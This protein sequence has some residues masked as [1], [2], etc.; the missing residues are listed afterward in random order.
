[1]KP[2]KNTSSHNRRWLIPI[3][4]T[5]VMV[6]GIFI[7][8]YE[9]VGNFFQNRDSKEVYKTEIGVSENDYNKVEKG[10][11]IRTGLVAADGYMTVVNNCT[12]CHSA[13]LVIQNRMDANRWKAT[14]KWMQETQNL[15]ELGENEQVIINYLVTNY[16]PVEKGRRQNLES[17]EWYT[18]D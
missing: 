14:I 3:I 5:L 6:G 18:L 16:P 9:P 4:I 17:V 2:K 10:I 8:F 1:M 13:K 15:W 7:Y 12:N 11:H